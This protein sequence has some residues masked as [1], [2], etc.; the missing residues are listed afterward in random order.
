MVQLPILPLKIYV[1]HFHYSICFNQF[2]E[3]LERE[4]IF[5]EFR[6]S[7]LVRGLWGLSNCHQMKHRT[8]RYPRVD[9]KE[10]ILDHI[11]YKTWKSNY[12]IIYS[13]VKIYIVF[14]YLTL[15][16]TYLYIVIVNLIVFFLS[17]R[18]CTEYDPL[19]ILHAFMIYFILIEILKSKRISDFELSFGSFPDNV[20]QRWGSAGGISKKIWKMY[21][22][23]PSPP[24]SQKAPWLAYH[25]RLPKLLAKLT[26]LSKA[27]KASGL[28]K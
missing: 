1:F 20:P 12:F 19:S 8:S 23:I 16:N 25:S 7:W 6:Y 15:L 9:Q 21:H 14:L 28:Q 18:F 13:S 22:V 2:L 26:S 3:S 17:N 4:Q 27:C 10:P 24:E 11:P 5:W